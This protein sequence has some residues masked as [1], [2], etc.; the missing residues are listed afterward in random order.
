MASARRDRPID[1]STVVALYFL[2]ASAVVFLI[3][4]IVGL[5]ARVPWGRVFELLRSDVTLDALRLSLAVSLLA[6][7]VALV[8]GLP[9]AWI[10]SRA[11]FP[12]R[13]VVRALVVLP[14]VLPPVVGGV[15][16]L[17]AL[18][19]RGVLG[20][21]LESLGITLPFTTAGAVVAAAF[22][23]APFLV[24]ALE[25]GFAAVD[26]SLEDAAATL[27]GSRAMILRTIT[28]PAAAPSIWA[29]LALC[30]ARALGEFGA[31][32]TFAGNLQRRT[33]T[34]PLAVFQQLERGDTD[35]AI[36]SS[37]IMLVLALGIMIALRDRITLR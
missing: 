32:I 14:M 34:L 13:R 21:A 10:L 22:V 30:W 25:A 19:R 1:R 20:G 18:G 3:L 2:A 29:G 11:R 7:L 4:P 27:G 15:G 26:R 37:T 6:T 5:L 36:L 35:G 24:V 31:T 12:G 16:L 9:L 8:V 28:I 23:G 17:T 33:Q